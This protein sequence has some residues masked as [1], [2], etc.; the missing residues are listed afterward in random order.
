LKVCD[1]AAKMT[2]KISII[3]LLMTV[4]VSAHDYYDKKQDKR[5]SHLQRKLKKLD[6]NVS[7][8]I[9]GIDDQIET[10][11]RKDDDIDE[12]LNLL[13]IADI[14][15]IKDIN[16]SKT[17]CENNQRDIQ[18]LQNQDSSFTNEIQTLKTQAIDVD[19]RLDSLE[20]TVSALETED[21]NLKRRD[22]EID[23]QI[24]N[25]ESN[26]LN[27]QQEIAVINT[28]DDNLELEVEKLQIQ[29]D[30]LSRLLP[31]PDGYSRYFGICYRIEPDTKTFREAALDCY[32][33]GGKLAEPRTQQLIDNM[34]VIAE[35]HIFSIGGVSNVWL[36]ATDTPVED[37][38]RWVSDGAPVTV[39]DWSPNEP[40]DIFPGGF[41]EHCLEMREFN[42]KWNDMKCSEQ[43]P[44]ICEWPLITSTEG[45]Q[46]LLPSN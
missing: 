28:K 20:A 2:A 44:Y 18:Q 46:S 26:V 7:I 37:V 5:I 17:C 25:I 4:N 45:V 11:Q 42:L 13:G 29:V 40:N 12:A 43:R 31:C 8:E 38:W 27:I 16:E 36:G 24:I 23:G 19:Q 10:L 39:F 1:F 41:R 14:E 21:I 6:H 22:Q 9:E 15:I 3:I 35:D 30:I 34:K 32:A 33:D